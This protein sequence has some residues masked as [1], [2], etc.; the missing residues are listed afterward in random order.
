[1]GTEHKFPTHAISHPSFRIK[2]QIIYLITYGLF[3]SLELT[4]DHLEI[5]NLEK[6]FDLRDTI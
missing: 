6:N 1:M 5:E 3:K 2:V 4:N